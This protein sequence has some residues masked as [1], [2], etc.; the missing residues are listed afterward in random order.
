[1][2]QPVVLIIRDGW[3]ENHQA[4]HDSF[5]AVKLAQTPC[6]DALRRTCPRTEIEASGLAVGLPEGVIGNS[7]VGHQNIGAGRIVVQEL[8]RLNTALSGGALSENAG[9]QE[10][11]S[12]A[13]SGG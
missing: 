8:V 12:R 5:N 3:G 11:C 7:E 13:R 9:F 1:M 6:A 4:E 2:I 10:A